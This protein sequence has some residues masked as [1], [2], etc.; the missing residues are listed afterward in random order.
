LTTILLRIAERLSCSAMCRSA[1]ELKRELGVSTP[2][3]G[4]VR[5]WPV[6]NATMRAACGP[7]GSAISEVH[8]AGMAHSLACPR[9][10]L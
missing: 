7:R 9:Y 10:M 3:S 6:A 1:D 5:Y 2:F 4:A 8:V